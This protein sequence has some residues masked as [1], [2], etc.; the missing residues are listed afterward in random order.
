MAPTEFELITRELLGL[1]DLQV[2]A[3]AG[4]KFN[5]L[6]PDETETYKSRKDRIAEL[7][8]ALEE[9]RAPK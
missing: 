7:R 9:L 5:H 6:S 3:I 1:L 8:L 2:A 4:R